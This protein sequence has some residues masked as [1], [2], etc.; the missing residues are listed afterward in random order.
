MMR[1]YFEKRILHFKNPAGTSRG[2]LNRKPSWY[3]IIEDESIHGFKAIGECSIIPGLSIDKEELIESKLKEIC[4]RI[5]QGNYNVNEKIPDFPAIQFGIETALLDYQ[6]HGSKILYPSEFTEGKKGIPINGLIW[7]GDEKS[8]LKQIEQKLVQGFRCIKLKIGLKDLELDFSTIKNLRTQ[9]T[10]TELEIRTDANGAYTYNQ[11]KLVLEKLKKLGVHSIEQP[12]APNQAES[13]ALLCEMNILP[14]A[15]DEE[16]I[17]V[18]DKEKRQQLLNTIKP[19]FIIIKPSLLGGIYESEEWI[20]LAKKLKTGWWITSALES[21]IALNA[22][23][24]WTYSKK[25]EIPQG[26]GT[27]SLYRKNIEA[28]LTVVGEKLFYLPNKKWGYEFVY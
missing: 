12:I 7:M 3:I 9:Y 26:L 19:Q 17:G 2:I 27:G 20:E 1:V 16:L 23:A 22:I 13:M 25:V 15:L 18:A 4:E 28:P 11:A 8:V 24:Q 6:A 10:K 14:I 21:N 5:Q